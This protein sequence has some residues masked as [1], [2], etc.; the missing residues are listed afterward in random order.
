MR[1]NVYPFD[2]TSYPNPEF[3]LTDTEEKKCLAYRLIHSPKAV[4]EWELKYLGSLVMAYHR[5]VMIHTNKQR[6]SYC[7]EIKKLVKIE[8]Q[9]LK[10]NNKR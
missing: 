6:N 3:S 8:Q 1:S 5:I 9:W 2:N 4:E 7:N 10:Q